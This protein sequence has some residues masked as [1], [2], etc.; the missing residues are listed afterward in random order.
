MT[1][2]NDQLPKV[3]VLLAAYNGMEWIEEQ[4]NSILNQQGV[5]VTIFASV[6]FS[7]DGTD[8][9][10]SEFSSKHKNF[11]LLPYGERFG[12]AGPNFFRLVRDV[13][14]SEFDAVSFADQDDIWH[15]WKLERALTL[16]SNTKSEAYSSNVT[17]FWISGKSSLIKKD[18]PQVEYDY[19]F[20]S[21]GPGC[22]FVLSVNL[23]TSIK[24]LLQEKK[25]LVNKLWLHDWFFY[26]FAR[27]RGYKWIIDS[28]PTMLYRQHS[29]NSVGANFGFSSFVQRAS[30]LLKGDGIKRALEQAIVL[31]LQD[32]PPIRRLISNTFLDFLILSLKSGSLRRNFRDKVFVFFFFMIAS[33]YR[34]NYSVK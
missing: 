10:L 27:S 22:T 17:A 31:D 9:W 2:H 21:A 16:M 14:F 13:E 1:I 29:T 34:P 18:Y 23:M 26:A 8:K 32:L 30:I 19:L 24:A 7:N 4:L 28:Q 20:E 5:S 3:A 11:V 25:S 15:P 12:G 6:D 33:I